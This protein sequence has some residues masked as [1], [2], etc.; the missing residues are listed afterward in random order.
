MQKKSFLW[1]IFV[2][3]GLLFFW[4]LVSGETKH[5]NTP[6]IAD[7]PS[8]VALAQ[9]AT[10]SSA[11]PVTPQQPI[12]NQ[13]TAL[14]S[15]PAEVAQGELLQF[16]TGVYDIEIQTKGATLT[17]LELLKHQYEDGQPVRLANNTLNHKQ[18]FESGLKAKSPQNQLLPD[19][20]TVFRLV[21]PQKALGDQDQTLTLSFEAEKGGV[22]LTKTY[23]FAKDKYDIALRYDVQNI[24]SSAVQAD[25]FQRLT[26]DANALPG[27]SSLFQAFKGMAVYTDKSFYQKIHYSDV[28]KDKAKFDAEA[29]QGWV[30]QVQHYFVL[31]LSSEGPRVNEVQKIGTNYYGVGQR[32]S[33]PNLA[34]KEQF[35]FSSKLYAG[36][37]IQKDLVAFSPSLDVVVDYGWLTFLAKPLFWLL[38]FLQSFIGNWGW[39]IIAL[40]ILIKLV[41]FPLSA[42]GYR[43]MSKMRDLAPRMLELRQRHKDDRIR[44]Q[45]EMMKLYQQEKVNPLGGCLPM[46]IPIPVFLALYWVLLGSVELRGAHWLWITDLSSKDPWYILPILMA[47][48][49][50][51]QA[52]LSPPPTD[53]VQAKMMLYMPLVFSVMFVW[54]PAGLVLYWVINNLFSIAQQWWINHSMDKQKAEQKIAQKSGHKSQKPQK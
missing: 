2:V 17:K 3:S 24:G 16:K 7:Q 23:V 10:A 43:S 38:G 13:S 30:A 22:K 46:I 44:Q 18:L 15:T 35:S 34:P 5:T 1:S 36:P 21:S 20:N 42:S 33:M 26:R 19:E 49:S 28:D 27:E 37:Q 51:V 45:Q 54:F 9:T 32:I 41:F 31:A 53:P 48:S 6:V 52:K 47:A 39:T 12:A 4:V 50:F 40:T 14:V 8:S 29:G 11:T 25:L